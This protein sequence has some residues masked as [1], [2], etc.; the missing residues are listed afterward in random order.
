MVGRRWRVLLLALPAFVL[1]IVAAGSP[2]SAGSFKIDPVNLS[3]P[4][5]RSTTSLKLT[6]TGK[7]PVSVR[8]VT[9]RWTQAD[10]KDVYDETTNVI[11]SPPIFTLAPAQAQLV[12]IGV[13]ERRSG[14][15]YRVIFE[16]IPSKGSSGSLVQVALR[17]NLPLFIE[18]VGGEPNVEWQA[19]RDAAGLI[20]LE[21]RNTGTKYQKVLAID[22]NSNRG[23]ELSLSRQ[24]G[25]VLP[26]S[27]RQWL[28]GNHPELIAGSPITLEIRTP[29][30]DVQRKVVVQQR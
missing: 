28:V 3:I 8:A 13:S 12:R 27:S 24:M 10:G 20:T 5:D 7:E 6:N 11:V 18:A 16:E 22:A 21:A 15:A 9:Y 17:L 29:S 23:R 2:A 19:W 30:G 26:A 4:A 1:G 25:V 14:D